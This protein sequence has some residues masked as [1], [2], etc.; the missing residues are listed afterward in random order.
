M[1]VNEYAL[2]AHGYFMR[3]DRT[4]EPFRRLYWV[5]WNTAADEK[6]KI[7]SADKLRQT[8]PLLTDD[9]VTT[10]KE[11]IDQMVADWNAAIAL[12]EKMKKKANGRSNAEHRD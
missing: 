12:N 10:P 9:K 7:R 5:L 11:T 2:H 1:S 4:Q 6:G 3:V 8:W